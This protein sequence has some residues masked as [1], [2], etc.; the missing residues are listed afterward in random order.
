MIVV[1]LSNEYIRVAEGDASAGEIRVKRLISTS[2]TKGCILNGMVTD[3]DTFLEV[4]ENLWESNHLS[5]KEVRL[6]IDSSQ[7]STKVVD[8]PSMKPKPLLQYVER[9]FTDMDRIS[10]PVYGYFQLNAGKGKKKKSATQ[11][12]L[13]VSASRDM[14]KKYVELFARMG[15]TLAGIRNAI[16]V[17]L[18]L[19]ER[20]SILQG[21]TCIV[22]ILDDTT[23]INLLLVN[24]E[25]VY[26]ARNRLFSEPETPGYAVEAA[27]GVSSLL[28]FAKAQNL[29][30]AVPETY[31]AGL[32]EEM[33]QVYQDSVEQ[34]DTE[35]S[36]HE[37]QMEPEVSFADAQCRTEAVR[38]VLGIAGLIR[39]QKRMDILEQLKKDPE[40]EAVRQ[41][42]KKVM[43]PLVIG[44]G[45][46]LTIAAF[47]G[48]Q[49]VY[50]TMKLNEVNSYNQRADVIEACEQYDSIQ[51]QLSA[52][53]TL[54]TSYQAQQAEV[55]LYPKVDRS[56]VRVID[57]CARGQVTASCTDYSSEDGIIGISVNA[58]D[59]NQINQFIEAL[60]DQSTFVS[61]QYSGYSQNT[62]GQW[63]ATVECLLSGR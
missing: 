40:K 49:V 53:T 44:T 10:N 6:L 7:L 29:A 60:S 61:V 31:V 1:H 41:A 2:D 32:T 45:V 37:L 51:S 34:I 50:Y 27:K 3:E 54:N 24:G 56:V 43:I 46:L 62:D 11:R 42:K 57:N 63:T 35:M 39:H 33:F 47:F 25:S 21:K 22:Q 58:S 4:M 9:E 19:A 28:Q 23:L 14:L 12:V 20:L 16:G 36:V 26:S 48:A 17:S 8:A 15:I 18:S 13:A 52:M 30:E 59:A 38:T 5:K 55:L